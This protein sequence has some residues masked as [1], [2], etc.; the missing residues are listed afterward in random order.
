MQELTDRQ[1]IDRELIAYT[2]AGWKVVSQSE[3]AFQV[4]E[5][6]VIN[7]VVA[8]FLVILPLIL[9]SFAFLVYAPLG[10]LLFGLAFVCLI[11][12]LLD[13]FGSRPK[14]VYMTAEQIRH[15]PPAA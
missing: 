2:A 10:Q 12:I 5:Q 7:S 13:F 9:G 1:L 15:R 11:I 4:A 3:T 8:V 6:K 14:L